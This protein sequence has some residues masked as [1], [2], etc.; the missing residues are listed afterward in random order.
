MRQLVALLFII[1]IG[2]QTIHQGLIYTYY[3][4]NKAYIVEHLCENKARP[5]LKCNGKCHLKEV[6]SIATK[7]QKSE[8]APIPNLEEIK[9]PILFFEALKKPNRITYKRE[10]IT[11]QSKAFFAYS[12]QYSCQTIRTIFQPPQV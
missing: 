9:V 6:L 11:S 12:F 4:L 7:E 10:G 1:I 3:T 8:Q 2:V 5:K